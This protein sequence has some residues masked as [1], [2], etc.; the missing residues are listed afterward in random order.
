MGTTRY[1]IYS[2]E[3]W[4]DVA[5]PPR[6]VRYCRTEEQAIRGARR[7]QHH[8]AGA[9]KYRAHMQIVETSGWSRS[10]L[11]DL[12]NGKHT[13]CSKVCIWDCGSS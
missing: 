11:I 10:A 9:Q 8:A 2:I 3:C 7:L 12:L 1:Q 6:L 5:E 4:G 13:V